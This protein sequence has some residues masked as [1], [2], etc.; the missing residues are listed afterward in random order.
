MEMDVR[1]FNLW[2]RIAASWKLKKRMDAYTASLLPHQESAYI[3]AQ[4]DELR[5]QIFDL[6]NEEEVSEIEEM[7]KKRLQEIR[8][9]RKLRKKVK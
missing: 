3:K 7:A 5:Y 9:K 8:E 2:V 6:D 1:D 4:I